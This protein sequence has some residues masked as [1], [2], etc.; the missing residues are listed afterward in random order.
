VPGW[1]PFHWLVQKHDPGLMGLP[2]CGAV[3]DLSS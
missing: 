3:D 2:V 1:P